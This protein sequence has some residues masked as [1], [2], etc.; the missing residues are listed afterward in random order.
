MF[1]WTNKY[2]NCTYIVV[3]FKIYIHHYYWEWY[4]SIPRW[5]QTFDKFTVSINSK[6]EAAPK[7]NN[8]MYARVGIL[9]SP[10]STSS[11]HS[12]DIRDNI[13]GAN[14]ILFYKNNGDSIKNVLTAYG[15]LLCNMEFFSHRSPS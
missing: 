6:H 11:L 5:W 12:Y 13:L 3:Q 15:L 4:I 10:S 9:K 1:A 14:R 2:L 8:N 7:H